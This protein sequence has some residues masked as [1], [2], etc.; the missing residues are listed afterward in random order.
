MGKREK[1]AVGDLLDCIIDGDEITIE[2]PVIVEVNN[3]VIIGSRRV[4]FDD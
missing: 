1:E 3:G 4:E 2:I